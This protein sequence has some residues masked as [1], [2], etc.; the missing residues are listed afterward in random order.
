MKCW[1]RAVRRISPSCN[2]SW[3][4]L[5]LEV[6]SWRVIWHEVSSPLC[7]SLER[8]NNND[9]C[10]DYL[11]WTVNIVL[12]KS[13]VHLGKQV[14]FFISRH[15]NFESTSR[16]QSTFCMRKVHG[17]YGGL[18]ALFANFPD[19][20]QNSLPSILFSVLQQTYFHIKFKLFKLTNGCVCLKTKQ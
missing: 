14:L 3:S 19:S 16:C 7:L 10:T 13:Q 12:D 1:K 9:T 2:T 8:C 20:V 18:S 5:P 15:P 4:V 17:S 6:F 11:L